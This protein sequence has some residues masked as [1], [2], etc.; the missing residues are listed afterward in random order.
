MA[1]YASKVK[2]LKEGAAG[3]AV[4][5]LQKAVNVILSR[6]RMGW[7]KIRPDGKLGPVTLKRVGFAAWLLGL[8]RGFTRRA[9]KGSV[10]ESLQQFIRRERR[11]SRKDRW[12]KVKRR[13]QIGKIRRL[14]RRK[15]KVK[16]GLTTFDGKLV[17]AP[18]AFW[19]LRSREAGWKGTLLSG[20]RDPAYSESLCYAMCGAPSCPGRC[21]GRSSGHSQKGGSRS[22]PQGCAD[23]TDHVTFARIQGEIGSPLRNALGPADP[24]HFSLSGR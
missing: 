4:K 20:Y 7:M 15:P 13:R 1:R 24:N 3:S 18:V 6:H 8:D 11:R 9:Q 10:S 14:H 2:P 23:I 16:D 5:D 17:S 21:A 12:R 22:A 19:L